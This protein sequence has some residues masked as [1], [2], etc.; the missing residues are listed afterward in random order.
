MLNLSIL[1]LV[2]IPIESVTYTSYG[3]NGYGNGGG[4]AGGN[5]GGS[6]G[7]GDGS[8]V[9]TTSSTSGELIIHVIVLSQVYLINRLLQ[10]IRFLQIAKIIVLLF[11]WFNNRD[12]DQRLWVIVSGWSRRNIIFTNHENDGRWWW[13]FSWWKQHRILNND[14]HWRQR[15]RWI[16]T[17]CATTNG[18]E[19]DQQLWFAA[20]TV[21][22]CYNH[23]LRIFSIWFTSTDLTDC[24]DHDPVWIISVWFTATAL[25][26]N[27]QDYDQ[28]RFI[29]EVCLSDHEQSWQWS[30]NQQ[31]FE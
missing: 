28:Q 5:G 9:T 23:Q 27:G 8:V 21:T 12:R 7:G 26:S 4:G 15:T 20:A 6:Y 25:L 31:C 11:R 13:I 17:Y 19:N 29:S 18:E 10:S 30:I 14:D 24:K 16:F 22:D 3:G 2:S 1:L